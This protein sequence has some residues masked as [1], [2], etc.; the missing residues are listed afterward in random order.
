[1][2]VNGDMPVSMLTD[3]ISEVQDELTH[4]GIKG[5][6]WGIRRYQN[7]DGSLTPAG[8]KKLKAEGEK[9]KEQE[10]V[11]KNR[12][13]TKAKFDRLEA[14]RKAL[15]DEKKA[16]DEVDQ[17]PKKL[18][19]GKKKSEQPAQKTM[20]DMT[21]E[22]L[23]NA[24]NRKRLEDTY[25]QLHP[26]VE[27]HPVMNKLKDEVLIPAAVNSGKK[28]LESAL[29]KAAEG[30]LKTK[31]DPNSIE[32]LTKVR[33][34]LKLKSEIDSFKKGYSGK[35]QDDIKWANLKQKLDYEKAVDD[36]KKSADE[37]AR[38]AN[39]ARSNAEYAKSSGT[40]NKTFTESSSKKT[41]DVLVGELINDTPK[42]KS[43]TNS[44]KKK[45]Y[46]VIDVYDY[47]NVT[48]SSVK[49]TP[50]ARTGESYIAGLL[51][52]PGLPAPRDDD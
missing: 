2:R 46:D 40:Y 38:V 18:K 15:D 33:D 43:T 17:N 34:E 20:K 25:N 31:V 45:T 19:L 29:T 28:F 30:V 12:K 35:A 32:A 51:P 3:D 41:N 6:R 39:E 52:A 24:I 21:D 27:K 36:L 11:L 14:K 1:M 37:A 47:E 4:W 26:K 16:L 7:K 8:R 5:M 10:R 22:E 50:A 49:N 23:I 44:G 13:S 9:L 42:S 48:S